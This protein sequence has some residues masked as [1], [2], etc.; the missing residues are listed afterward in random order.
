M[1]K[2]M[3]FVTN[4]HILVQFDTKYIPTKD[5]KNMIENSGKSVTPQSVIFKP[6]GDVME[7]GEITEQLSCEIVGKSNLSNGTRFLITRHP[8]T[9]HYNILKFDINGQCKLMCVYE[10]FELLVYEYI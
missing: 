1:I 9:K 7:Q 4:N 5:A 3:F 2:E 8:G 10:N 6:N